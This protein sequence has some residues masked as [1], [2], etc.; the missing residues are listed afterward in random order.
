MVNFD[1]PY[2]VSGVAERHYYGT[3]LIVDHERGFVLVDRNTV[4]VA[5]GD[6]AITFA[7]SLEITGKVESVHPLHNLAIVSYDPALI[8]DTPVKSALLS[9]A[10]LSPGDEVLVV[11]LK[12]DHQLASQ[13]GTV[14]S[15]DPMTLPLSRTLRFREANLEGISL[16]NEPAQMDGVLVDRRGRVLATWSSFAYQGGDESNQMNR[17][18]ASDLVREFV[19]TVR[20]G[21]PVYSLEAEFGYAPLF[22]TRKLGLDEEWID[23]LEKHDPQGRRA[24]SVSRLVAGSPAAG[25]MRNG[26]M[27]LAIDGQVVSSFREMEKAVQKPRVTATIWRDGEAREIGIDTVALGGIGIDHAVSW[28][29]AL[30]QDPHRAMAVQRGIDPTGVYVAYFNYGSPATRYGLW[31]GRRIVEVDDTP[32]PDLATF[33]DIVRNKK[34]QASIRLRTITWNGSVEVITLKLDNQYWPAYEIRRT[35][36]G[37]QRFSIG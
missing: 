11:G 15:V 13:A 9:T 17:G 28:A 12:A 1:L 27:L 16:V 30:L 3:G 5:M 22:A 33:V 31:A 21:R 8:G 4:P 34:D 36:D 29:G 7:G 35:A 19:D 32:T 26:D 24:L 25:A 18:I 20:E 10:T 23:R 14:A 2:T 37:W 6:V